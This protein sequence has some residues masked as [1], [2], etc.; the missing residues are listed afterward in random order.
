[1][2]NTDGAKLKEYQV[3][4]RMTGQT[5]GSISCVIRM[6]HVYELRDELRC[7]SEEA[8]IIL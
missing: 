8:Q 2:K 6:C 5:C 4:S 3:S 1:M 7:W